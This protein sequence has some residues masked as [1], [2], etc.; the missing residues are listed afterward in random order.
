MGRFDQWLS[1][2]YGS[3]KDRAKREQTLVYE[4]LA[5]LSPEERDKAMN[6][7]QSLRFYDGQ[8][9]PGRRLA[10]QDRAGASINVCRQTREQKLEKLG[11]WMTESQLERFRNIG[12]Q[13]RGPDAKAPIPKARRFTFTSRLSPK[14][15]EKLRK[16]KAEAK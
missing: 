12:Q 11:K 14:D 10:P 16:K 5:R 8:Y 13:K 4:H 7:E 3:N 6:Q 2:F 9:H 15:R 1:Q